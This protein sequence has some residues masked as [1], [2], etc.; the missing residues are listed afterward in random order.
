MSTDNA[1][2]H[3]GRIEVSPSHPAREDHFLHVM[4][5]GEAGD[6]R[7]R[8]VE[9]L[10]GYH[11]EGALVEDGVLALF[12]TEDDRVVEG[13]VTLPDVAATLLIVSGLVP[14]ARYELQLTPNSNPG[15]PLW[16]QVAEADEHGLVHLPWS[17]HKNA[18]LRLR[19]I[20]EAER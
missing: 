7:V 20:E 2:M 19:R 15:A 6:T 10:E 9:R 1:E 16:R 3:L 18:R 8:R 4:E 5:I 14:Q 12:D 11:L 13:E 17:E